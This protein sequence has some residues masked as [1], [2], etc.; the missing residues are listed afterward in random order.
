MSA[1]RISP[2]FVNFKE[3]GG[4]EYQVQLSKE[5]EKKREALFKELID[6]AFDPTNFEVKAYSPFSVTAQPYSKQEVIF[7]VVKFI[8]VSAIAYYLSSRLQKTIMG[9]TD[10]DL[11]TRAPKRTLKDII[12]N[13]EAKAEVSKLLE[14]LKAKN[15]GEKTP[16]EQRAFLFYGVPGTGKTVLAEAM[17]GELEIPF[18]STAASEFDNTFI[19]KG[20][21]NIRSAFAAASKAAKKNK[22]KKAILFIDEIDALVNREGLRSGHDAGKPTLLQ[23]FK[24]IDDNPNVIIVA[25]T[26]YDTNLDSALSRRLEVQVHFSLPNQDERRELIEYYL[27]KGNAYCEQQDLDYIAKN[28]QGLSG[29]ILENIINS[30]SRE[31]WINRPQ[32]TDAETKLYISRELLMK[33][34]QGEIDKVMRRAEASQGRR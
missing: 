9:N 13:K 1:I 28:T 5:A 25:A 30:A 22:N 14:I 27:K 26:N 10:I 7:A 29:A 33:A 34:T 24:S 31:A 3:A 20:S 32:N 19:G 6:V 18:I 11:T 23:L 8:A 4:L 17:A 15:N 2:Y 12:G 16:S 21:S